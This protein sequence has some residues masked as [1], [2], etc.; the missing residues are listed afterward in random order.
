MSSTSVI[1]KY[2]RVTLK[3]HE[4]KI[5]P[6]PK[7]AL[8]YELC[9][10]RIYKLLKKSLEMLS[11]INELP[12]LVSIIINACLVSSERLLNLS[13]KTDTLLVMIMDL[14]GG[15]VL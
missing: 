15:A 3:G 1:P 2:K 4:F 9:A 12:Y 8:I 14:R 5:V 6:W 11:L 13:D 7:N 10:F